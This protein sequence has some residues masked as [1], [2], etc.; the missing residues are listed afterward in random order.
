MIRFW[1]V[2]DQIKMLDCI[3]TASW[4]LL[5]V[6]IEIMIYCFHDDATVW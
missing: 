1:V 5:S 3:N 6:F 4:H 2:I